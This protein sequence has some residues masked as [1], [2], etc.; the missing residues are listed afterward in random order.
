MPTF[1]WY[2]PAAQPLQCAADDLLTPTSPKRPAEHLNFPEVPRHQAGALLPARRDRRLPEEVADRAEAV[3]AGR[4][5][6][7]HVAGAHGGAHV[8]RGGATAAGPAREAARGQPRAQHELRERL[9][10]PARRL[11]QT[12]AERFEDFPKHNGNYSAQ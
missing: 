9:V 11:G 4:G 5:L 8:P 10:N 12:Y 6:R 2:L 7:G 1:A 3:Q